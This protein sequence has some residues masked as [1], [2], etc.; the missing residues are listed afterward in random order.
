MFKFLAQQGTI[1]GLVQIEYR[2]TIRGFLAGAEV[3]EQD[4]RGQQVSFGQVDRLGQLLPSTIQA[5]FK[6]P[7]EFFR[8]QLNL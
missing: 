1:P 7:R 4:E 2:N 6:L 3:V 8:G 5:G